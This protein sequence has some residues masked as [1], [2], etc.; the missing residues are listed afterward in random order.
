M[1]RLIKPCIMLI[2]MGIIGYPFVAYGAIEVAPEAYQLTNGYKFDYQLIPENAKA[3]R[4][5]WTTPNNRTARDKQFQAVTYRIDFMTKGAAKGAMTDAL[6]RGNT[7]WTT[8]A[9]VDEKKN[10]KESNGTT[11]RTVD[12]ARAKIPSD[13]YFRLAVV[14]GRKFDPLG[15]IN[16]ARPLWDKFYRYFSVNT[17]VSCGPSTLSPV[18]STSGNVVVQFTSNPEG[19][20]VTVNGKDLSEWSQPNQSTPTRILARPDTPADPVRRITFELEGYQT[21]T[22]VASFDKEQNI[23]AALTAV[24]ND[25]EVIISVSSTPE[26]AKATLEGEECTTPCS[27]RQEKDTKSPPTSHTLIMQNGTLSKDFVVTYDKNQTIDYTFTG[28]ERAADPTAGGIDPTDCNQFLG[29]GKG[30]FGTTDLTKLNLGQY[31]VCQ[32]SNAITDVV[33]RVDDHIGGAIVGQI[34]L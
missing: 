22:K 30:F 23:H 9:T 1:L 25:N 29:F 18:S 14:K 7:G 4:F 13:S 16:P 3:I 10:R 33:R 31:V 5:F 27:F 12:D 24:A 32:V 8:L 34:P 15:A 26:K 6:C 28:G 2:F 20:K 11:V 19:A 21:E 17:P